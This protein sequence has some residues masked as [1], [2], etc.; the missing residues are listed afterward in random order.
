MKIR[1]YDANQ[2]SNPTSGYGLMAKQIADNLTSFGH[3]VC[4][5]PNDNQGED[6]VLWIRPPHYIKNHEF[7]VK[8]KNVIFTMH[9]SDTFNDWKSD[10]PKLL[11][12]VDAI[13]TPTEWNKQVFIKN[14]VTKPIF[15]VPLGVNPNDFHGA[16]DYVFSI[17]TLHDRLGSDSSRENWK[18]TLTAYYQAFKDNNSSSVSLTIKSYNINR[19][20]YESFIN[21]L[22][23]N[24]IGNNFP[25]INIV[26]INLVAQDLNNLYANHWL[27]I[28]NANREGWSLP[29]I[30]AMSCGLPI[31]HTDIP[32]LDWT[33]DYRERYVFKVGDVEGLK[34]ILLDK[35]KHWKKQKGYINQFKWK[36]CAKGV[37]NVLNSI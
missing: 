7:D 9:E 37:E 33:K 28:K 26:D 23:E 16:K 10:W 8:K 12:K 18:D 5:Y 27:F 19:S 31:A 14:G 20:K 1:I 24:Y 2:R 34:N 13:I 17:L 36:N 3:G 35:F 21:G 22:K 11:N 4:F 29:L 25:P 30:E 6:V 32:V 15:V